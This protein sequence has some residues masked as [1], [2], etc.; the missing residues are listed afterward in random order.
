MAQ[1]MISLTLDDVDGDCVRENCIKIDETDTPKTL[2]EEYLSF[3]ESHN[4]ALNDLTVN[5]VMAVS[6]ERP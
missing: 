1:E 3:L 4:N 2:A 5:K 6:G